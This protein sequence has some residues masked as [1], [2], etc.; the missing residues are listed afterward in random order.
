MNQWFKVNFI[1][2]DEGDSSFYESIMTDEVRM[3]K[4]E[5]LE[6]IDGRTNLIY[7]SLFLYEDEWKGKS[8]SIIH[9]RGNL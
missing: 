1:E 8:G 3:M 4:L 2:S 7:S 6:F 9:F 5:S